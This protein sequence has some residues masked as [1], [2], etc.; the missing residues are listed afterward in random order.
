[1]ITSSELGAEYSYVLGFIPGSPGSPGSSSGKA[2]VLVGVLL[3][4]RVDL[5]KISPSDLVILFAP[6]VVLS[7]L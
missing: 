3:F 7:T 5:L 2:L 6:V 4:R 1:M